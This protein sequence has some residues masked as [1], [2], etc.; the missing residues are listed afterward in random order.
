MKHFAI[1]DQRGKVEAVISGPEDGPPA[2][3]ELDK[4]WLE[5]TEVD[6]SEAEIDPSAFE[7]E[8]DAIKALDAV[9][10]D[11]SREAKLVRRA[12]ARPVA[13]E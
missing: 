9:R 2:V 1:H 12:G 4:P 8:E 3:V 7:T 10:I 5:F 6:L 13:N 11:V